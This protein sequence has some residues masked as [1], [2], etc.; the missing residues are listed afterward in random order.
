MVLL[1]CVHY[2]TAHTSCHGMMDVDEQYAGSA[3]GSAQG[4]VADPASGLILHKV[5]CVGIIG[6]TVNM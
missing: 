4:A 6:Y 3:S 2:T 5:A 1:V